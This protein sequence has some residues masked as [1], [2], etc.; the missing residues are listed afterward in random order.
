MEKSQKVAKESS[1]ENCYDN[2]S[3]HSEYDEQSS[4][5][6]PRS[7]ES[8]MKKSQ[9]V[10][11]EY[12]CEMCDYTT[13][14]QF[15]YTKHLSTDKHLS[16]EKVA[17]SSQKSQ[18]EYA[19]ST[20]EKTYSN[21]TGLWRHKK[22]C[23]AKESKAC[24]VTP[25]MFIELMKQNKE[26][27]D[28]VRDGMKAIMDMSKNNQN[29]V[30]ANSNNTTTN[31]NNSFNLTFFLNEQCKNAL[32]INDFV[33]SLN[34]SFQDME[35]TGRVGFVEGITSIFL[36]ALKNLDVYSRP[37]HCTDLKREMLYV[38]NDNKWEKETEDK[39]HL[40]RAIKRTAFKNLRQIKVW[41]EQHPDYVDT[42]TQASEDHVAL[43]QILLGGST[44][45][46]TEKLENSI[47]RKVLRSV[48]IDKE[49]LSR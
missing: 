13:S 35:K 16:N 15:N 33:D 6:K 42:D 29:N 31:S 20:C 41:E 25:E 26:L 39:P 21:Y 2:T 30:M 45:H 23:A 4:N 32:N 9:K 27:Q 46:E 49:A 8:A 40:R 3:R 14:K 5:G 17:K 43:S 19:C 24:I 11:K 37:I 38:K 48:T 1:I 44:Q 47:M 28:L 36:N 18:K 34:P 10:A 7:N 12:H 22:T